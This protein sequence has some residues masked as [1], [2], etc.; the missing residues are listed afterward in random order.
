M[1][2]YMISSAANPRRS[3]HARSIKASTKVLETRQLIEN[4]FNID[5]TFNIIFTS[6]TTDSLNIAIKGILMN[7]DHVITTVLEHN[8]VL[9]PLNKLRKNAVNT[10]FIC[11]DKIR[12]INLS[13]LEKN[14]NK[15]I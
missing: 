2:D 15:K 5:N 7:R 11:M 8:S 12:F 10:T 6:N 3:T 14:I 1:F 9:R 13:I 4:L